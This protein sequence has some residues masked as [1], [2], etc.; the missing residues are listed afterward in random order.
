MKAWADAIASPEASKITI[1][2]G[3]WTLSQARLHGP[4]KAPLELEVVGTV[5]AYPDPSKMPNK[6]GEWITINYVDGFTL[7]G[8]GVFDGQGQQAWTM[9]DCHKNQNCVKLP[10]VSRSSINQCIN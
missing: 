8:G 4:N 9:N 1:P 5:K 7:S 6:Q 10:I 3:T 2:G